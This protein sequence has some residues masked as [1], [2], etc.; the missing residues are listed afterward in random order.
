VDLHV[1]PTALAGTLSAGER[2][3]IEIARGLS[4]DAR[5]F[6]FDE[7]TSSLTGREAARLF[8]IIRR[9]QQ[10]DVAVL[11]ISHN[12]DEVL[13]LSDDVLVMRDGRVALRGPARG[14]QAS[15][16]VLAMVGRP[17]DAMFPTRAPQASA[18][19]RYSKC[20]DSAS[21]VSSRTSTFRSPAARSSASRD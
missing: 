10:R 18:Q 5:V 20:Q 6:I 11:Y 4:S 2:Q 16:L 14:L 19:S 9:L 3:L 8:D 7:P 12:L 13:L 21:V 17:I 1:P 15:D